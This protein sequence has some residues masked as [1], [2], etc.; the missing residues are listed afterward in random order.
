MADSSTTADGSEIAPLREL[1]T[2]RLHLVPLFARDAQAIFELMRSV[3]VSR[4]HDEEP[5]DSMKGLW[6][7]YADLE[8]Q[9]S[10]DGRQVWL[11]WSVRRGKTGIGF[12]Q[13]TLHLDRTAVI[14]YGLA[15]T[16]WGKG[17][18]AEAVGAMIAFLARRHAAQRMLASV[19]VRNVRS[20]RLL[21]RLCFT[22]AS[23]AEAALYGLPPDELLYARAIS[24]PITS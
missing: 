5:P 14:A 4:H 17:F 22:Q 2:P 18:A 16:H 13:A 1:I 19:N 23:Q 24:K 10:E 21:E 3:D 6:R 15:R 9:S 8:R 20:I 7:M 11:S 12:V